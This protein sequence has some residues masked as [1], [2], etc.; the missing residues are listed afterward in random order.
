MIH[1]PW[2]TK[3]VRQGEGTDFG[4][5]RLTTG[6]LKNPKNQTREQQAG[7]MNEHQCFSKVRKK[8]SALELKPKKMSLENHV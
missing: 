1:E 7:V 8:N 6:F 2:G 3:A 4:I 5:F